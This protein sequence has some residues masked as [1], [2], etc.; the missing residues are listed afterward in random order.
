MKKKF[1]MLLLAICLMIPCAFLLT[2]CDGL[3]DSSNAILTGYEVYIKGIK[4]NEFTCTSG[5]TAITPQDITIKSVWTH[6]RKNA[7]VPFSDFSVTVKWWN[8]Y[9]A[10]EYTMPDFWTNGTGDTTN[11]YATIYEFTLTDNLCLCSAQFQVNLAPKLNNNCRIRIFNGS[12][13]S[14]EAQMLWG[15][16]DWETDDSKDFSFDI[17]NLDLEYNQQEHI[18]WAL[19]E[20]NVYDSLT[21]EEEK[22]TFIQSSDDFSQTQIYND[23]M[24]GT[25]YVFAFVPRCNNTVYGEYG[26]GKIY[27]CAT[28]TILPLQFEQEKIET[29]V[30][31]HTESEREDFDYSKVYLAEEIK[32][33]IE[34]HEHYMYCSPYVYKNGEWVVYEDFRTET[35]KVHAIKV[36]NKYQ[37]VELKDVSTSKN[38]WV[39]I[40]AN[41]TQGDP[42]T[43]NS[44]IEVVDYSQIERY[45][46]GTSIDC[47]VY[48]MVDNT[49][50][51]SERYDCTNLYQT[52]L[53]IKKYLINNPPVTV[54]GEIPNIVAPYTFEFTYGEVHIINN[55]QETTSFAEIIENTYL[56]NYNVYN[57]VGGNETECS[58]D[59]YYAY[60]TLTTGNMAWLLDGHYTSQ[61]ITVTYYINKKAEV[62]IPAFYHPQPNNTM[63]VSYCTDIQEY[64][65]NLYIS[66]DDDDLG[67]KWEW[68]NI[69]RYKLTNS[70]ILLSDEE[71]AT[72]VAEQG[73]IIQFYETFATEEDNAAGNS[74]VIMYTINNTNV[75]WEDQSTDF[76][77][78]KFTITKATQEVYF[79]DANGN[80]LWENTFTESYFFDT[81]G[82]FDINQNIFANSSLSSETN[83]DLQFEIIESIEIENNTYTSAA[84]KTCQNGV[85]VL[86]LSA[87]S[88][89]DE[90]GDCY[91]VLK[92]TRP[93]NENYLDH[94]SIIV[95]SMSQ[96]SAAGILVDNGYIENITSSPYWDAYGPHLNIPEGTTLAD[97]EFGDFP[98]TE[99]GTYS[100]C[101]IDEEDQYIRPCQPDEILTNNYGIGICFN[102]SKENF[103]PI[104]KE[105]QANTIVY[106]L[107]FV[108]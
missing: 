26:D 62:N 46:N 30:L 85:I 50:W 67:F 54:V 57:L 48:F 43:D 49:D 104:I 108:K 80:E 71:L 44:K 33:Y 45:K 69:Y 5:E 106:T 64:N 10:E 81:N 34:E 52:K 16:N 51:I 83:T 9:G 65:I 25:Y 102:P 96:V 32:P 3:G 78:F 82:E 38:Q 101:F 70:D 88:P 23:Y 35:L 36:D 59:P 41:G 72:K 100:W 8:E 90:N 105:N 77:L 13:Y 87:Q 18:Q 97:L 22:K 29:R 68:L 14:Y 91:Y 103:G 92:V 21:S 55:N 47:F 53:K 58:T 66:D 73:E 40:N 24:P 63:K 79:E 31:Q 1:L 42:V 15:H 107:F 84:Y 4:T 27:N 11:D 74:F 12:E 6:P 93:G 20:K 94:E 17:E 19:I 28:L 75:V 60:I 98:E 61:P 95:L 2:A 89:F 7:D 76:K 86:N 37:L 39:F 99:W 56:Q